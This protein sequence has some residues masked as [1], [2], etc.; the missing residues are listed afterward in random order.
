MD[1]PRTGRVEDSLGRAG[2]W[3]ENAQLNLSLAST[4][5]LVDF[6]VQHSYLVCVSQIVGGAI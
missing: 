6:A 3:N 4:M 5:Y 2:V 1:G